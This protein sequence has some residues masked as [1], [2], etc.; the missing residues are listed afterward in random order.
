ML[1]K[2]LILYLF[3]LAFRLI[4]HGPLGVKIMKQTIVLNDHIPSRHFPVT[5]CRLLKIHQHEISLYQR[6]HFWNWSLTSHVVG[7]SEQYNIK[8]YQYN[9]W[10]E[11]ILQFC[12][13]LQHKTTRE[14]NWI[15]ILICSIYTYTSMN[16]T[17]I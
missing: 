14:K 4:I 9:A 10:E 1:L 5:T 6:F 7:S 15:G 11:I 17:L 8:I 16:F 3:I 13:F 2:Q 12:Q